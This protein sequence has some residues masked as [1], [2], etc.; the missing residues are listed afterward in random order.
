M[1]IELDRFKKQFNPDGYDTD[2]APYWILPS[3]RKTYNF[4]E[5]IN[6]DKEYWKNKK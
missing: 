5:W 6:A 1:S 3:D 4:A 2:G